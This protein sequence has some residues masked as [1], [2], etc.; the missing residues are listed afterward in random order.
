MSDTEN[1]YKNGETWGGKGQKKMID[2][3]TSQGVK[4]KKIEKKVAGQEGSRQKL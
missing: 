2:E 1:Y 3:T 4:S